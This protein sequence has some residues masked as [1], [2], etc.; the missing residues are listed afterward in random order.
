MSNYHSLQQYSTKFQQIDNTILSVFHINILCLNTN[1]IHLEALLSSLPHT[2]DILALSETWLNNDDKSNYK[3]DGYQSVHVV[4]ENR[5]R[6]GV[7]LFINS[8]YDFE[9]IH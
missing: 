1:I 9:I 4:R 3:L 2:P 6:G 5:I 8:K 7:S